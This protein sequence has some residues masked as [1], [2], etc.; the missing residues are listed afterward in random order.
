[1]AF[2]VTPLWRASTRAFAIGAEVN[3]SLPSVRWKNSNDYAPHSI[4]SSEGSARGDHRFIAA[5]FRK[6]AGEAL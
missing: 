4:M 2:T 3:A 6:I 1:M 5:L